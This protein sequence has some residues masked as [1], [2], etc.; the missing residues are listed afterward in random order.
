MWISTSWQR[1]A[2]TQRRRQGRSDRLQTHNTHCATCTDSMQH[3]PGHLQ[4]VIAVAPVLPLVVHW[5]CPYTPTPP[6]R[7]EDQTRSRSRR[8]GLNEPG[9]SAWPSAV[10]E[11]R[12]C[13]AAPLRNRAW[14]HQAWAGWR[15]AQSE[16]DSREHGATPEGPVKPLLLHRI[17]AMSGCVRSKRGKEI[18][19]AVAGRLR[20]RQ[21]RLAS[22]HTWTIRL[23]RNKHFESTAT[24]PA[25]GAGYASEARR[26]RAR[27]ARRT[28]EGTRQTRVACRS[29]R[30]Q[31]AR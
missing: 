22:L 25:S 10:R 3:A 20:G 15:E 16:R 9:S 7:S 4:S 31:S 21:A 24:H 6:I 28:G 8:G 30:E 1:T 26:V 23:M 12:T 14:A 11:P 29:K 18:P 5:L 2:C 19:E 27:S 17:R 13:F